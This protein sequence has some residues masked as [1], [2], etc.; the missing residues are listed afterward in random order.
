K[1]LGT[2]TSVVL[3]G[4]ASVG[5]V[6]GI[7]AG[8]PRLRRLGRIDQLVPSSPMPELALPATQEARA[9]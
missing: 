5:V 7:G 6:V 4:L 3:G 8:V 1:L 2:V 9:S